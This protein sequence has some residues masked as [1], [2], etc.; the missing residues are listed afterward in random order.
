MSDSTPVGDPGAS[1][2]RPVLVREVL[3]FLDLGPG[4]VVVDGTVGGGGHSKLILEQL[5]LDG[6]LIGL[7]LDPAMLARASQALTDA[8]AILKHGSYAELPQILDSLGISRVDRV[9]LDLGL[10]SDQLA[11]ASRGFGIQSGMQSGIQ[12]GGPLDMRFDPSAGPTASDLLSTLG[13]AEL[14]DLFERFGEER[15][16]RAI[17]RTIVARRSE[18]A[19]WAAAD[20]VATVAQSLPRG[21]KRR[22]EIHPATRIFQALRIA[23]NHELEHLQRFLSVALPDRLKA[24]GRAVI[25]SFHSL[26]DRIV[27]DAFRDQALWQNLTPKP[28]TARSAEQRMNPRSRTAK[29]RAATRKATETPRPIGKSPPPRTIHP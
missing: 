2:H 10:S 28:V 13:E 15:A 24:D 27:K 11:D 3:Q 16:S 14:G 19:Q 6:K 17:A 1:V 12:G 23:V 25:I 26:E 7:D 4:L 8:R 20:L 29:L 18:L 5:G 21:P 9:L 22:H